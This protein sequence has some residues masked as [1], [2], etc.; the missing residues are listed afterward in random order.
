MT[1]RVICI[2]LNASGSKFDSEIVYYDGISYTNDGVL[3]SPMIKQN[4]D[5][6]KDSDGEWLLIVRD[7][8]GLNVHTDMYGYYT[9]F[10][11]VI[12]SEKGSFLALSD[13]FSSICSLVNSYNSVE[14][15]ESYCLPILASFTPFFNTSH[16]LK[17]SH[18]LVKKLA[19]L[20]KIKICNGAYSLEEDYEFDKYQGL[21]YDELLSF[22]IESI[23]R[24]YS[25]FVKENYEPVFYLSGGKDS[26]ACL[27]ACKPEQSSGYFFSQNPNNYPISSQSMIQ[28]DYNIAADLAEK[29][30]LKRFVKG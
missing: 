28:D 14:I 7:R 21:S 13:N 8:E 23:S 17:T 24:K 5:E 19:P 15:D 2:S 18:L 25:S 9:V 12:E 22:G 29:I 30:G 1:N 3:I 26:R 11:S 27:A 16:S 4:P 6:I 10:Y 20:Q